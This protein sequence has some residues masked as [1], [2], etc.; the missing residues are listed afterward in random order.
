[1]VYM[2]KILGKLIVLVVLVL[3][4]VLINWLLLLSHLLIRID[5]SF[6]FGDKYRYV[7]DYP[8]TLIYHEAEEYKGIGDI[9]VEGFILKYNYDQDYIILQNRAL[10]SKDTL[11]WI[12][13][14]PTRDTISFKDTMA[15][16]SALK[17]K[18]IEMRLLDFPYYKPE[19]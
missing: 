19:E 4:I 3:V 7:R 16:I 8:Q 11:Y 14:K 2:K 18:G 1:M 13:T 17:E 12:V 15:F 5:D 9:V 6:D 10:E